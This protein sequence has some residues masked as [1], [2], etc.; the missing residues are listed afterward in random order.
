MKRI[1]RYAVVGCLSIGA[2]DLLLAF[3]AMN[4]LIHSGYYQIANLPAIMIHD[5][6][7][8]SVEE[9]LLI[10]VPQMAGIGFLVGA[11]VGA[12]VTI[13]TRSGGRS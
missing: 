8:S 1:L 10:W 9:S 12:I 13:T 11:A 2:L 6:G 5:G 3:A 7:A 4:D